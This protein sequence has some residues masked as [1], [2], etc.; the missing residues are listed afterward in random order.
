MGKLYRSGLLEAAQRIREGH[1]TSSDLTRACLARQAQLEPQIQAWQHLD[2]ARAMDLAEAADAARAGGSMVGPLHGVPLA[3][4]DIIDVAGMPTTMGSPIYADKF[5]RESAQCVKKLEQAG[6]II[7]GKTVTTEFAY[8]TPG[9]TRNPW[10]ER[11][12][13]G[14]SSSGSAAAVA[15]CMLAGTLGSQTNGSVIRPAAFCGAVGYKPTYGAISTHGV[16][17]FS[18]TLDTVGVFARSVTD[19][20]CLAAVAA[21]AQPIPAEVT[22]RAMP[23]RLAAVRTPVWDAAETAQKEMFARNI[24]ALQAAGARVDEVEL[25]PAFAQ[26]HAVQRAIMAGEAA[27]DLGMLQRQHR[28]RISARLNAFLDE[29]AAIDDTRLREALDSRVHLQK[30]YSHFL[31]DFDAVITPPATGEAPATLDATGDPTFCTIWTLLGAPA[32][33]I[34]VGLGPHGLPLGLQI[35]G[36]FGKDDALLGAAAWCEEVF[37]FAGLSN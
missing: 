2:A 4:K 9:K 1:M 7:V 10:N 13:P 5:A 19:A 35:V 21:E 12:T 29:G 27:R 14:G 20:A 28:D 33:S 26:A 11:H 24:A 16:L 17:T 8:Y 22:A 25:P 6:A 37:P 36:A 3:I 15:C 32:V 34:P 18:R 31:R 23:P 30:T